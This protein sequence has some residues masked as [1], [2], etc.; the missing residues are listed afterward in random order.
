[1]KKRTNNEDISFNLENNV[2]KYEENVNPLGVTIDFQ[3]YF[4]V[5]VSNICKRA[6]KQLNFSK[7]IGTCADFEN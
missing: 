7:R 3:V 4:N 5:H 2:I 1:M 6:S